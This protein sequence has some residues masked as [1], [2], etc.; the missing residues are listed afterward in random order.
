[1][2]KIKMLIIFTILA[3][4]INAQ[5]SLGIGINTSHYKGYDENGKDYTY[6][7]N[8]NLLVLEYQSNKNINGIMLF[9]N[10]FY[11]QSIALYSGKI[12]DK[13]NKGLYVVQRY[14]IIKGYNK[15]ESLKSNTVE[16]LKYDFIN[17]TVFYQ[18][19]SLFYSVGVGY[20]YK[21]VGIESNILANA[22]VTS[23][24]IEL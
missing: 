13:N 16:N 18:D 10:S 15:T 3:L 19:Y 4:S 20:K 7:E 8:N 12:Y 9:D 1:M 6:N 14:G 23:I 11:N 2:N 24:K 21:N 22:V 5:L 17:P